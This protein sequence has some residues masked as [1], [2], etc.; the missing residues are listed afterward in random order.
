MRSLK[1]GT[2]AAA[3]TLTVPLL[4]I[5]V[6][7]IG[8]G[9]SGDAL[10]DGSSVDPKKVPALAREMLPLITEITQ[11]SCPELPPLWVIA[12]VQAESGWHP[13]A[14]SSDA[15]G[16]AAGLYQLNQANWRS[17][18][19]RAWASVPPPRDADVFSAESHLRLAIPWV[20]AN[21]RAATEHITATRKP[22]APLDAMLVCH[23][24]GCARVT[25][26][27]TGVP[28]AGEAGCNVTCAQQVNGYLETVH[29]YVAQY[30]APSPVPARVSLDGLPTPAPFTG[31]DTG[32]TQPDPTTTGCLT[33]ATQ[34]AI[35]A[36][37]QAF[38]EL[39]RGPAI[40]STSCWSARPA[41]QRSDHPLGKACDIFPG[42]AG[43]F[44]AGEALNK[45]WDIAAWLRTHAAALRVSYIIW[46]G[47]IWTTGGTDPDGWGRAYTGGG[48]HDPHEA[49][50]GHFD[51]IH[52]SLEY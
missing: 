33:A 35:N 48:I 5:L 11:G 52:V 16:G 50:G 30:A 26:S 22:T 24:A 49:T 10:A 1:H 42:Q 9:S 14:F 2:A 13:N 6:I 37:R 7:V 21:L 29:R 3:L 25:A 38:G 31:P 44:A 40:Q 41:S 15:N 8:I 23:I 12:A 19:G 34:H 43:Q 32:C 39:Q 51:H 20:C 17:A 18:G 36:V 4:L 28:Q 45:G 47:R 46:Q 27:A